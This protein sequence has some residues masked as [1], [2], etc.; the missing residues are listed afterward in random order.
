MV[1]TF[2]AWVDKHGDSPSQEVWKKCGNSL[3]MA[4]WIKRAK[5][6][7]FKT[8]QWIILEIAECLSCLEEESRFVL[9]QARRFLNGEDINLDDLSDKGFAAHEKYCSEGSE[10]AQIVGFALQVVRDGNPYNIFYA[11]DEICKGCE[12]CP[13]KEKIIRKY[14]PVFP[15]TQDAGS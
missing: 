2:R 14:I 1:D 12:S 3:V 4:H 8:L 5:F 10:A 13:F 7:D 9:Q 11:L 15:H 6:R